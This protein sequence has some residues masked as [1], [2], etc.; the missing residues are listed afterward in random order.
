MSKNETYQEHQMPNGIYVIE[1]RVGAW[2]VWTPDD[3]Q[4]LFADHNYELVKLVME[5]HSKEVIHGE[6]N[7]PLS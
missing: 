1:K 2:M 3:D 5:T 6:D 4:A 7:Q